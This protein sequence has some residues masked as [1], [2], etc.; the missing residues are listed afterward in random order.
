MSTFL[1]EEVGHLTEFHL[2][3]FIANQ[4]KT[5]RKKQSI[6]Q[7]ASEFDNFMKLCDLV[8]NFFQ[9]DWDSENGMESSEQ[10]L[11]YQRKAIIG[12]EAE[13]SYFKDKIQQFLKAEN[14]T[15]EWFPV[16][17]KDLVSGIF[18]QVWG[19]AGVDEW[20]RDLNSSSAKIIGKNIFFLENGKQVKKPQTIDEDRIRQLMVALMLNSPDKRMENGYIEV[21]MLNGYRITIFDTE[22]AKFPYIV[23]RKYTMQQYTFKEVAKLRTIPEESIPLYEAS[24]KCGFNVAF[25]GAV[26]TSKTSF[27]MTY[28]SYEDPTLEGIQVETDPEI[29]MHLIM[30]SAPIMQLVADGDQL[31]RLM[32]SIMRSDGDYIVMAEARDGVALKIAVQ[33]ANKGTRR[34][35][36]TFHTSLPEDLPYDIASEI[37]QEFGGDIFATTIKVAKAFNYIYHFVQLKDKSQK[38]LKGMYEIRY[39]PKTLGVS[40]HQIMRYHP[41]SESWTYKYDIGVDKKEI[42]MEEDPEAFERFD[43]TLK[44]LSEKYPMQG[45]HITELPYLQLL[46]R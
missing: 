30:P 24:V 43:Q 15:T 16:W 29:P 39:N 31:K 25:T 12:Y 14:L 13:V 45:E 32:K 44:E 34:V 26:R 27:L 1:I 36:L 33:A 40:I 46:K 9:K 38:R 28:Q 35:K 22:V 20:M 21:Y 19:F 18:Q 10:L 2:D 7:V 6:T 3:E 4:N 5:T 23:F 42:G 17:Y 11:E 37:G 8:Q 41:E